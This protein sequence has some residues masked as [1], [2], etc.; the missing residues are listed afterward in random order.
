MTLYRPD[1]IVCIM[2]NSGD[3]TKARILD[4]AN[5]V[6]MEKGVEGFTLEMVALEAG[7]SKGGLLYHYP[8][9]KQLIQ[10][11][12]ERMIAK[13]DAA[14][15]EELIKSNGDYLSAY[16]HASFRTTTEPEKLSYALFAAIAN[17][18]DLIEPLRSRFY[19]IQDRLSSVADV[20]P[21][22]ATLIRLSLDGLWLS[23][24]HGFSPP[25][26]E[27]RLKMKDALLEIYKNNKSL[28]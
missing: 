26:V 12:I 13:V 10:G 5:K 11:M 17:E 4:A 23:D 28:S 3:K 1:G 21:E 6:L 20:Q 15:E 27:M 8:S 18:P 19:K 25:S 22:I 7:V 2:R 24:L 14:L 9:K 16:I